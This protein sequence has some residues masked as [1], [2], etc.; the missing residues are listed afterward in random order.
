MKYKVSI[1]IP[2]HNAESF[3]ERTLFSLSNQSYKNFEVIIIDDGST[4]FT[5]KSIDNCKKKFK[6]LNIIVFKNKQASGGPAKPANIGLKMSTS[7]IISFLDQ[8]D[9]WLEDK[10]E[11]VI[12][13]FIKNPDINVVGTDIKIVDVDSQEIRYYHHK[14][15]SPDKLSLLKLITSDKF[16]TSFSHLSIR[17]SVLDDIGNLDENILLAADHDFWI[18]LASLGNTHFIQKPLTIYNNHNNNLSKTSRTLQGNLNDSLR[19]LDKHAVL[20]ARFPFYFS[21]RTEHTADLF[22]LSDMRSKSLE[23]YVKSIR[24]CPYN[25]MAY[26]K[27]INVFI[28][29]KLFKKIKKI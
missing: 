22:G 11:K 13:V 28:S 29:L 18:R 24:L 5:L 17:K 14:D 4:D 16:F 6:N 10:L 15:S 26:I 25:L 2:T 7:E 1:I 21:K 9:E 12:D 20:Y 27:I 3:I 19:L 8:D 23:Y